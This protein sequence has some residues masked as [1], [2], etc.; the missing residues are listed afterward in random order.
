[1]LDKYQ[2]IYFINDRFGFHAEIQIIVGTLQAVWC[3]ISQHS[4][5]LGGL[6]TKQMYIDFCSRYVFGSGSSICPNFLTTWS[7]FSQT[8]LTTVNDTAMTISCSPGEHGLFSFS[9]NFNNYSTFFSL[10]VTTPALQ[11][12]GESVRQF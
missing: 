8:S 10:G 12:V 1:M 3:K 9:Q 6:K 2:C 4:L 7:F 5:P 11:L